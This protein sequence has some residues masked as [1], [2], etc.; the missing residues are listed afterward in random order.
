M[1]NSDRY[2]TLGAFLNDNKNYKCKAVSSWYT[3]YVQR[4]VDTG[5][6]F[7]C[8]FD[9]NASKI[10]FKNTRDYLQLGEV[11]AYCD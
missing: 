11:V 1:G 2:Q 7:N 5:L 9:F 3:E 10:M 4:N 8:N 6:V